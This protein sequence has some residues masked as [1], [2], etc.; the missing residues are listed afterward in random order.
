MIVAA[1]DRSER[2]E[3][4]IEEA[5]ALADAFEE[6]LHVVHVMSRSEF[7]K[8]ETTSVEREGETIDLDEIR[9]GAASVAE[10][11]GPHGVAFE[12]VGMVGKPS[13]ELIR[14]ASEHNGS[15]IVLNPG[16]RSPAGKVLFGSVAQSVILH[17]ECPVVAAR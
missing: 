6:S 14:Y 16:R 17:A 13:D 4:V 1:V 3:V 5:V 7:V 8:R 12:A 2:S 11:A 10:D 15:H 9:A